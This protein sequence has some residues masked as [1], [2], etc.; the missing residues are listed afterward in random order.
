MCV[1]GHD[2]LIF[3]FLSFLIGWEFYSPNYLKCV[4]SSGAV[5]ESRWLSWAVHPNEPSGFRGRKD[6]LN[7]ASALVT[8][9][10]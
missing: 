10:P 2:P 3:S 1:P 9:C 7:H 4:H 6:I 8:T 5:C